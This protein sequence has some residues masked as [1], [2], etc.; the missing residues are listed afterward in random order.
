MC[1]GVYLAASVVAL[2]FRPPANDCL[3]CTTPLFDLTATPPLRCWA[4]KAAAASR[5]ADSRIRSW[6]ARFRLYAEELR[7]TDGWW[8]VDVAVVGVLART[9]E[10]GN[11]VFLARPNVRC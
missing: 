4:A 10:T 1:N 9:D 7:T 5:S 8:G 2:L 3:R 11:G 6:A